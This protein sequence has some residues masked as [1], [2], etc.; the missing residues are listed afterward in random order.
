MV[1]PTAPSSIFAYRRFSISTF[2]DTT[3]DDDKQKRGSPWGPK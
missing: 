2:T 3:G 1:Q